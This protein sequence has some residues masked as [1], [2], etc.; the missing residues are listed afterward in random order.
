MQFPQF[1]KHGKPMLNDLGEQITLPK[2]F[3]SRNCV[4]TIYALSTAK[5]KQGNKGII[6]EDYEESP[7]GYEGLLDAIRYM[8][9][10]LFHD[11]GNQITITGGF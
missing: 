4:N 6:K 2:F 8:M 5:F 11:R 7:D 10:Y 3:V 1:D 9:V